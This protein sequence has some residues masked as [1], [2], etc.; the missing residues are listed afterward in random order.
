MQLTAGQLTMQYE[1]GFL[2][3]VKAGKVEIVRMLYFALRDKNWSTIPAKI[4]NEKIEQQG[5]GFSISYEMLFEQDDIK[6]HWRV[7]I[8]GTANNVIVFAI[9][10]I[11]LTTF[12]KNRAGFCVLHPIKECAGKKVSITHGGNDIEQAAFP[13]YI[14]PHQPFKNITAMQWQPDSNCNVWL[15]FDGDVF[16]TEDHR[17]WTDN[18]FKTYCTPLDIPFPATI[19]AGDEV[20]QTISLQVEG[21]VVSEEDNEIIE[22]AIQEVKLPIPKIGIGRASERTK[23]HKEGLKSL[24]SIGFDYYRVDV[25]LSHEDWH[26]TLEDSFKEE[27]WIQAQ[28]EIALFVYENCKEK[29]LQFAEMIKSKPFIRHL[30]ILQQNARCISNHLLQEVLLILRPLLPGIL[31]GAGTDVYFTELNRSNLQ[32]DEIDFVSYSIN[33]QV[34]AFDDASLMENAAAQGET[35]VA[36]RH[37]FNKPVYVSPITLKMRYNADATDKA[38]TSLLPPADMRQR[39]KFCAAWAVSSLASLIESGVAGITYFETVGPRG[40]IGDDATLFPVASVF[41]I[42]LNAANTLVFKSNSTKPFEV[43]SLVLASQNSKQVLIANQ[44]NEEKKVSISVA[45][46]YRVYE[47]YT[48]EMVPSHLVD[49]NRVVF[50]L[51]GFQIINVVLMQ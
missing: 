47:L 51:M 37:K 3:W 19:K 26:Q 48:G 30:V 43:C 9:K 8:T 35:V 28:F 27:K 40:M 36:A 38:G 25:V 20:R 17:N 39:T 33:P 34:H 44:T 16:E 12:Q 11:A 4:I 45:G 5:G 10:G 31:I 46:Q 29:L 42:V 50:T 18:N 32:V 23:T 6:M 21:Y 14:S 22:V 7:A 13:Y 1:N 15:K 24:S 41:K 49:S 2:R